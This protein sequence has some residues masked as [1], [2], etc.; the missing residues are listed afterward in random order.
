[1]SRF[2]RRKLR[3]TRYA[4]ITPGHET[5]KKEIPPS[6]EYRQHRYLNNRTENSH[7]PT[8]Q[9]E[10]QKQFKSPEHAQSFLAAYVPIPALPTA[11]PPPICPGLSTRDGSTLPELARS[12]KASG[13][14]GDDTDGDPPPSCPVSASTGNKLTIPS[15][16]SPMTGKL[17]WRGN[18]LRLVRMWLF[19]SEALGALPQ[20]IS[21]HECDDPTEDQRHRFH[22]CMPPPRL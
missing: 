19:G 3:P 18:P 9:R 4:W 8:R 20:P 6:V 21:C 1:L 12:H 11:T 15:S 5:A 10:R 14:V 2:S 17:R 16:P 22:P 7:Q 13:S